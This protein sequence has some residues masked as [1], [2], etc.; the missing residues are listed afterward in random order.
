MLL[1]KV[2]EMRKYLFSGFAGIFMLMAFSLQAQELLCDV[3]VNSDQVQQTSDKSIFMNMQREIYEFLNNR[4][5]TNDSYKVDERIR[6]K[7]LITV[8]ERSA[9]GE[10]K[11]NVQIV[12][13]RP[14]YGTGYETTVLS[15][16]D[17]NWAFLYNQAVPLQY[18]EN[19]FTSHLSSLL[20]FYAYVIIGM[21]NDSFSPKGGSAAYDR[22]IQEMNN[23]LAQGQG[24]PGWRA[25]E[26]TRNRY[27]LLTNLM[28]PQME[29]VRTAIYSYHRLGLDLMG[30]NP[31]EAR[32]GALEALKNIQKVN[33]TRPGAALT[34]SFFDAKAY[35]IVQ[36]LKG[37][38]P[39]EKQSA[40][41]MLSEVDPTNINRYQ[42]MLKK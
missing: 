37:A 3:V 20:A 5:W 7:L 38:D 26:D 29:P 40:Y 23:V 22:A 39:A 13:S 18:S 21:D 19:S 32:K 35:E 24:N 1:P 28:D 33:Q 34:R 16:V 27:W 15:F 17:K 12:S 8:T 2:V 25:F 10:C 9:T 30:T 6:C 42:T 14:V 11:A 36:F 4:R 31:G 41:T